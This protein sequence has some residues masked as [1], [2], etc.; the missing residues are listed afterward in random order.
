MST[1]VGGSSV[2]EGSF[3]SRPD[4]AMRG[5]SLVRT[6]LTVQVAATSGPAR[7]LQTTHGC[8]SK[9]TRVFF[10]GW[11]AVAF[12]PFHS[13]RSG[14]QMVSDKCLDVY[15]NAVCA[16]N[17]VSVTCPRLVA[18]G[19]DVYQIADTTGWLGITRIHG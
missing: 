8:W 18:V 12:S 7:R 5:G 2:T 17:Q 3:I 15:P 9:A 11:N 14:S 19:V 13:V 10:S 6:T 4:G 16:Y 1:S